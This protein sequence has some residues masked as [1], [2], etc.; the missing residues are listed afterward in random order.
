LFKDEKYDEMLKVAEGLLRD[1]QRM[2]DIRTLQARALGKLGRREEAI[3]AAKEGMKLDP[4]STSLVAFIATTAL[5]MG[6]LDEAEQHAQL[7]VKK[8]PIEAHR[9][10]A[11]VAL[12]RKDWAKARSEANALVGDKKENPGGILLLGRV[13][14]GEGKPDEALN[15]FRQ[16]EAEVVKAKA[17]PM[18]KLNFF[19]GDALARRGRGDEA[20]SAFREE[21]RLFPSDPQPYKNLLLLYAME[22]KNREATE[23]IFSLEKAAPSPAS[24]LAIA[25]TLKIIGDHNGSRFWAT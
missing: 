1:N 4:N 23:L 3:D 17:K 25:E 15:L 7:L 24:Y 16:S 22:G 9:L 13:A 12:E 19:I 8:T 10:L 2:L 20:E 5:E 18:P 14:L 11:Q 21:I 6:R